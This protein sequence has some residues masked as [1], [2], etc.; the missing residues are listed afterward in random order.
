M[1]GKE[2]ERDTHCASDFKAALPTTSRRSDR[3]DV[4]GIFGLFCAHSFFILGLLMSAGEN[5]SL[6]IAALLIVVKEQG[7]GIGTAWY[8]IGPCKFAPYFMKWVE[9]FAA[10][11]TPEE[12][13]WLKAIKF[14]LPPFHR[15]AHV[16]IC[17]LLNALENFAGAGAPSR[18][19]RRR[20]ASTGASVTF[21]LAS[22]LPQLS[23]F[24]PIGSC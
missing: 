22:A 16:A 17:Q 6:M 4:T 18:P 10:D 3:F 24:F 9:A 20:P 15:H 5:Y 13:G 12:L 1:K 19:A 11:L 8:D 21:C 14:P 7:C 23:R 2:P